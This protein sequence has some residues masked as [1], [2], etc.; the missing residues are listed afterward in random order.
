[1]S[2]IQALTQSKIIPPSGGQN[3]EQVIEATGTQLVADIK[4]LSE[5]MI[6]EKSNSLI[7]LNKLLQKMANQFKLMD[8]EEEYQEF[9]DLWF[10][11][12]R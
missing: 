4:S 1:L 12:L 7:L 2:I 10:I 3:E 6:Q 11:T 9:R 5:F 8:S